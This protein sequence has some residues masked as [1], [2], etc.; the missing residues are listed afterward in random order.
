MARE[1]GITSQ[2]R[3]PGLLPDAATYLAAVDIFCLTSYSEGMPNSVM[4][5]AAAGLPIV[6]T[7][8]GDSIHLI[9]HGSS[10]FLVPPNDDNAMCG[11]LDRLLADA[12]LRFRLGLAGKTKMRDE[13]TVATMVRRMTEVYDRASAKEQLS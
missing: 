6:S 13:F 4:E 12:S 8:C 3:L 5:A 2:V 10:G 7:T 9:E 11:Y 1:L